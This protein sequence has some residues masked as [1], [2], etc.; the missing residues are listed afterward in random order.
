MPKPLPVPEAKAEP[1]PPAPLPAPVVPPESYREPQLCRALFD[2]APALPDELRLRKGDVV[3]VLC[4]RTEDEGWWEG[5]CRRR[6]GLF[7][8]NFVE[9]LPPLVPAL[10]PAAPSRDVE[11]AS[12]A[13]QDEPGEEGKPA[14]PP[15]RM[16]PAK[17]PAAKRPAPAPPVPA[18][19]KLAP[20]K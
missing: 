1:R 16:E 8:K 12:K 7:P 18:K 11:R 3:Q 20:G 9:L 13:A 5:Q 10:Q 19:T 17:L 4:M 2:Y 15:A 6:R 14:E